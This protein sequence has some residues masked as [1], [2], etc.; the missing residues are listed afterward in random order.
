MNDGR[1]L[2]LQAVTYAVFALVVGYL[3]AS[4]AYQYADPGNTTIK[5][6]LSHAASEAT[7]RDW[8]NRPLTNGNSP[9]GGASGAA[10]FSRRHP[11]A[12][13]GTSSSTAPPC[14]RS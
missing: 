4:P 3:S 2:V 14:Q 8:D 6:S 12:S 10:A 13:G 1:R 7:S 5:L 9:P 11:H